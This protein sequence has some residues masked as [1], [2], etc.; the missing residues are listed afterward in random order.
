MGDAWSNQLVDLIVLAAQQAGFSGFFVY[1]PVPG[2]GNLILSIA[3]VAGTDPYGNTY[4]AGVTVGLNANQQVEIFSSSGR[5]TIALRMN[6][7]AFTN[8]GLQGFIG[9]SFAENVLAGPKSTAPG[10]TDGVQLGLNS[11]DAISSS[12]N[13][14]LVYND[15]SGAG[16]VYA[17]EDF[18]GFNVTTCPSIRAKTPA[19]GTS[20]SNPAVQETWH[21]LRPLLNSFVGTN[22]GKYPPQYQVDARGFVNIFGTVKLPASYGSVV[23]QT[24]PAAYSPASNPMYFP[25]AIESNGTSNLVTTPLLQ[26][27]TAGNMQFKNMPTGLS[28]AFV[29]INVSFPLE[30][31]G[32]ITS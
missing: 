7:A 27:D 16:H 29:D 19:S 5:G 8:G 24:L 15:A 9:G 28:G 14:Q 2:A 13:M 22:A 30:S 3:A 25:I 21:D 1:S 18:T 6:S 12:A 32:L 11:S 31:T 26:I 4:P 10:F 17:F 20:A 23:W